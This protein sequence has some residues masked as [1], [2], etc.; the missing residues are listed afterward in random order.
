V[1]SSL[2]VRTKRPSGENATD[3]T[4]LEWPS[5]ATRVGFSRDRVSALRL[6]RR[7]LDDGRATPVAGAGTS[8]SSSL[9]RGFI[10]KLS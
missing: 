1:V 7:R 10:E 8:A 2:P 6:R 5:C 3:S 9:G 4:V